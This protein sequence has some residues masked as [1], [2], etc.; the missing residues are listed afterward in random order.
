MKRLEFDMRK[1]INGVRVPLDAP[2]RGSL[3]AVTGVLHHKH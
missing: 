3:G 2:I 1:R